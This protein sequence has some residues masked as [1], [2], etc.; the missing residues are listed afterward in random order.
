MI[1]LALVLTLASAAA[2]PAL[3]YSTQ[4]MPAPHDSVRHEFGV[5][6]TMRLAPA[7]VSSN[8]IREAAKPTAAKTIVY[9]I[10]AGKPADRLDISDP[11]NN[12]FMAH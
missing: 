9:Q 3:A 2:S 11:K 8:D 12:P 5:A 10:P 4:S 1:R 7:S 6:A